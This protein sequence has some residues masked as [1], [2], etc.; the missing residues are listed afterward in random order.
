MSPLVVDSK[1]L[2]PVVSADNLQSFV[3][4]LG[5][6]VWTTQRVV[7]PSQLKSVRKLVVRGVATALNAESMVAAV[8]VA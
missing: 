3:P 8:H 4:L 7:T 1:G 5:D 6:A 2:V